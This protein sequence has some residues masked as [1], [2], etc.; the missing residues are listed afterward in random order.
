VD[1]PQV[2]LAWASDPEP[3]M[4]IVA[5]RAQMTSPTPI[6]CEGVIGVE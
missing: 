1:T 4:N 6:K 5:G 3:R 2:V